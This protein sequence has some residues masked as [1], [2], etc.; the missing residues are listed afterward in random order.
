MRND[1]CDISQ[2]DRQCK[3]EY[4]SQYTSVLQTIDI[5]LHV[6]IKGDVSSLLEEPHCCASPVYMMVLTAA[7]GGL[8]IASTHTLGDPLF[9]PWAKCQCGVDGVSASCHHQA[10]VKTHMKLD[11]N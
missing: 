5:R 11:M 4:V 10:K 9:T 7:V 2:N 1:H 3:H 6:A 8:I